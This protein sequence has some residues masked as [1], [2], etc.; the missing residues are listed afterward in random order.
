[1]HGTS[2][3]AGQQGISSFCNGMTVIFNSSLNITDLINPQPELLFKPSGKLLTGMNIIDLEKDI[4]PANKNQA[5]LFVRQMGRVYEHKESLVFEYMVYLAGGKSIRA[6]CHAG[7]SCG[8]QVYCQIFPYPAVEEKKIGL[9]EIQENSVQKH[10]A[11]SENEKYFALLKKIYEHIPVGLEL[12]DKEGKLIEI[13]RNDMRLLGVK[14]KKDISGFNLFKDPNIPSSVKDRIRAG[15]SAHYI[16]HYDFDKVPQTYY[17]T[18]LSGKKYLEMNLAVVKDSNNEIDKYLLIVQD[19]TEKSLYQ[20]SLENARRSLDLA[21]EA[22]NIIAWDYNLQTKKHR[23]L[24]GENLF[25]GS[26][27]IYDYLHPEDIEKF[28]RHVRSISSGEKEKDTLTLR[29]CPGQTGWCYYES[30]ALA[31]KDAEGK[32]VHLVGALKDLTETVSKELELKK[33]K[34]FVALALGAGNMA[35]WIYE[36][37]S[38]TFRS[39][40]GDALAGQGLSM[41]QN[42]GL[43][44]PEDAA[45]FLDSFNTVLNG[46]I[47]RLNLKLRY[48]DGEIKGGYRYY[49]TSIIPIYDEWGKITHA[50]GTQ[51][52]VTADY[53]KETE[54]ELSKRKTDLAI[55]NA[56]ITLW[57][58]DNTTF[59][60]TCYNEPVNGYDTSRTLTLED[61]GKVVHPDDWAMMKGVIRTM[62]QGK[63]GRINFETRIKS[64]YD[65]EW[66][67]CSIS[68]SPFEKDT[69]GKIIRY[70][71][72]RKNN[73]VLQKQ[74][75][76]LNTILNN[77]PIPIQIKDVEDHYKYVFSNEE[78]KKIFGTDKSKS[79]VEILETK[80]AAQIHQIDKQVF[81]TGIP[82]L[83]QEKIEIL[84]G[85]EYETIVRKS[86][87]YE[88]NKKLLLCV[89]WDV[90][91]QN[92]LQRKSKVLSISMDALKAFTWYC[93][94]RDGILIFGEGFEKTGGDRIELNSMRKFAQKIHPEH[95]ARFLT[96]ID[97][98]VQKEEGNFSVEYKVDFAGNGQYEWWECRGAMETIQENGYSYR[99]LYGMDINIEVHK[100][101]ELTLLNNK[102]ELAN[103]NRQNELVLNNTNSGLAYITCDFIVQWENISL[104]SSGLA[105]E[106]YRKGKLCYETAHGRNTPCE[107]CV[108][109]RAMHS[110]QMEQIAFD[111]ENGRTMEVFATPVLKENGETDGVVIRVDDI[112]ERKQMILDL[113]K[114][115]YQAEQSDKL[116]SAFL[117]NMSHE[118]RTPLNAIV[119]FSELLTQV[120]D[121]SEKAEYLKIITTNNELLL[122]LIS[123]ILD[124]SKIE[125]GFVELKLRKFDLAESFNEIAVSMQRRIN[126]P[127]IEFISINPYRYC[128]VELDKNRVIQVLTNYVTN[129]IKYTVKGF[130]KMGYEYIDGGIKLYVTDSGIGIDEK[131]K[132]KVFRRFEKL[133]EFAQG[134]GLGLSICKAIAEA[135]GGKTGF[136]S[137][138]DK[139]ST[140]WAWFP[141][142]ADLCLKGELE[143]E[144]AEVIFTECKPSFLELLPHKKNILVAEDID[145]NYFLLSEMLKDEFNLVRAVNGAEAVAKVNS[146]N[147]DLVFMDMKMPV[148]GG[149]EAT[150]Q[151]RK[152]NRDIPIIAL[153][154]YAFDSDKE[155]ALRNGC[156]GYLVKPI[157]RKELYQKIEECL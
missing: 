73:S 56:E 77:L 141:C 30:S 123:D 116:K 62:N 43:L 37:A 101:N 54:L 124:L 61:Y 33:Q 55:Q 67:Y 45:T 90:S 15:H 114:A 39:L 149:L 88:G 78:S 17:K 92:E 91:M 113:Q 154:A 34:S 48:R 139:G 96:L 132:D 29:L 102:A 19:I 137:F 128:E 97:G 3:F 6:V 76:L 145:S 28:Q 133:D 142:K 153:T 63:E 125:A 146:G 95:R 86:I 108:M 150:L 12:Y 68:G 66:Q 8:Q 5:A 10:S 50:T 70:V 80:R 74:K 25:N 2:H 35:V 20:Q 120:T 57:E 26:N 109:Q 36:I 155:A 103:L 4:L 121:P 107:N 104:C 147:F 75:N 105:Y 21:M 38:R 51:K 144:P 85:R 151:I 32:T 119:G 58:Y 118:I 127:E 47:P 44:H 130:I 82:Y 129:S 81:E 13:N 112:T 18:S 100:K 46:T 27:D 16:V 59:L 1:M 134:T 87:I 65:N 42:L 93:D 9:V 157:S 23:I 11:E 115:K 111:L 131:K 52:E 156:T 69:T 72:I 60:F 117:A 140:F 148:M 7:I 22:A 79:A 40:E 135:S 71:G 53:F 122:K 126:N 64:S 143:S 84:D 98:F 99:F 24:Y 31:V 41:E 14:E 136:E 94:M 106:A 89:R 83:G 49:E 110:G 152:F 138:K